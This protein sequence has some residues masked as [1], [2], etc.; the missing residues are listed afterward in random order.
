MSN[1]LPLS[2]DLLYL[3]Y[4]PRVYR[5]A[6]RLLHHHEAAEDVTQ[7][8]FLR[9]WRYLATFDPEKGAF[10]SWLYRMT[11]QVTSDQVGFR[12]VRLATISLDN[13][14]WEMQ[15]REA[16][17]P[18]TRYAGSAEQVAVA[19]EALTHNERLAL[20]LLARGYREVEIARRVGKTPRTVRNWFASGR[21]HLIQ[22]M[23]VER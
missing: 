3:A 6:Y 4:Y 22:A 8:T 12:K 20:A 23:E 10:P 16:A 13:L 2:F 21:T 15:D 7:E 1:E 19:L 14:P 17:D 11:Y 9:A 18:Q 5:W